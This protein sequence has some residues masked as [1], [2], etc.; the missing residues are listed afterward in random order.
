MCTGGVN[1]IRAGLGE[2][3]QIS[4]VLVFTL[5]ESRASAPALALM[6]AIKARLQMPG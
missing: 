2:I 6:A 4:L 1:R 3:K 5:G